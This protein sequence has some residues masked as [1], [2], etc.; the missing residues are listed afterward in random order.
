LGFG[1]ELV[2]SISGSFL[3]HELPLREQQR[4]HEREQRQQC[5]FA[6]VGLLSMQ[7]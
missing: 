4:Q 5:V 6:R 1:G 3:G 7:T 2:A